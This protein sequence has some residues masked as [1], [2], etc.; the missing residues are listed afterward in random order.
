MDKTEILKSA[1]A[2]RKEEVFQHQI[3]IDNYRR[4]IPKAKGDLDLADFVSQ[5][6]GLL[7]SSVIEQKKAQ[8]LVDVLNE[9]INEE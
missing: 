1:L 5:L 7:A 2:Q 3:N 4:A 8:I 6:E 9:Q